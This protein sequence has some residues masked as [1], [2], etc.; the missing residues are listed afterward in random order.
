MLCLLPQSPGRVFKNKKMPGR[1]GNERVTVQN[2][3][4]RVLQ[5]IHGYNTPFMT[6]VSV[7][8]NARFERSMR[9]THLGTC[10]TLFPLPLWLTDLLVLWQLYK[11]DTERNLLYVRGHVP[12]PKGSFVRV[13]TGTFSL[14]AYL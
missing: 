4:V 8:T 3:W 2:L 10:H 13:R 14:R 1:L 5:R 9:S 7:R 11:I 12:G 6:C